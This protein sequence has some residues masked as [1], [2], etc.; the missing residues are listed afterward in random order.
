MTGAPGPFGRDRRRLLAGGLG[1]AA[2][3][4]LTRFGAP[5]LA[6]PAA[7]ETAAATAHAQ[8]PD[9]PPA[10]G[11]IDTRVEIANA[12]DLPIDAIISDLTADLATDGAVA[13]PTAVA[14]LVIDVLRGG[15][16]SPDEEMRGR[17][18]NSVGSMR[19]YPWMTDDEFEER[20]AG[21]I[22]RMARR[23]AG[24][25]APVEDAEGLLRALGA[26]ID[27]LR[28]KGGGGMAAALPVAERLMRDARPAMTR[29]AT[30]REAIATRRLLRWARGLVRP[31]RELAQAY[32]DIYAARPDR[33]FGVAFCAPTL[34]RR[35]DEDADAL[36]CRVETLS[37]L[38]LQLATPMHGFVACDPWRAALGLG[39]D[40]FETLRWAVADRGFLGAA[41]PNPPATGMSGAERRRAGRSDAPHR[42]DHDDDAVVAQE[43]ARSPALRREAER[44]LDRL[45]DWCATHGAPLLCDRRLGGS[46]GAIDHVE[47]VFWRET[48]RRHPDLR[49]GFA[50]AGSLAK[51]DEAGALARF[52][53][54]L[55]PQAG[56]IFV[57]LGLA[58]AAR[59]SGPART[60]DQGA[61]HDAAIGERL[62]ALQTACGAARRAT[63]GTDW[64]FAGARTALEGDGER[65]AG[66]CR[67]ALGSE[68]A[69]DALARR[70]ALEWLGLTPGA[71]SWRRLE[72]YYRRHGRSFAALRAL[73]E[74]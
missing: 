13:R 23:R 7:A 64:P 1:G 15:A 29:F 52:C 65:L 6:G 33:P 56:A 47:A 24:A 58:Q 44:A 54:V 73:A 27:R 62:A 37:A 61:A 53:A 45:F 17:C 34:R 32:L 38:S 28:I 19:A 20:V 63:F 39:P 51:A 66:F 21:A 69:W 22:T 30:P 14:A 18:S 48:F 67:R 12:A 36:A 43:L 68:P 49:V 8:Q 16:P 25:A 72:S 46:V 35:L 3:A 57:D 11:A 31:R 71:P 70:S 10:L 2:G 4:T 42:L 26:P 50:G 9:A 41:L 59:R 5:L 40:A 60:A 55:G 74:V